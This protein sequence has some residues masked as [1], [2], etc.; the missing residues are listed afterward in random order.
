MLAIDNRAVWKILG[1]VFFLS[2][3]FFAAGEFTLCT[4][5]RGEFIEGCEERSGRAASH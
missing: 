4:L 5:D 3:T 2:V 1:S